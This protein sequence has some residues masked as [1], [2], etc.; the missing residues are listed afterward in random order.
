MVEGYELMG[1]KYAQIYY[2][3]VVLRHDWQPLQPTAVT[4]NGRVVTVTFHVPVAPLVWETTFS[5]PHQGTAA[6][7]AGKGFELRSGAAP[8]SIA[9][10]EIAGDTVQITAGEDLPA[11]GL[12]V[13]YALGQDPPVADGGT[14]APAMT[15][16]F[17][18]T[19]R[20]GQ[21]RDSDPFVGSTTNKAQPNYSVAFELPVP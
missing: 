13:G 8:V 19:F 17:L 11:S 1:E 21:L 3:R 14:T 20:W 6:W 2:E 5:A 15:Q 12:T 16:P 9:A 4:R 18:G 7:S 10:V